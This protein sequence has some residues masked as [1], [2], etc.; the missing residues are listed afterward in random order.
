MSTSIKTQQ[1]N[2]FRVGLLALVSVIVLGATILWLRGRSLGGGEQF[3]VYFHDVD[4]MREGAPVQLMGIRV[5]FVDNVSP[6]IQNGE[7]RVAVTFS[8]QHRDVKI[9]Q[10]ST[11]S[12]EQAGL[13]GEKF[14]EIT[15]PPLQQILIPWP[16]HGLPLSHQLPVVKFLFQQGWQTVGQVES[17][18]RLNAKLARVSFRFN[19]PG[20]QIPEQGV[21]YVLHHPSNM[22]T[23]WTLQARCDKTPPSSA[24]SDDRFTILEPTRI[25]KFLEVQLASAEALQ[26]TNEKINTLLS[27]ATLASLTHTVTNLESLSREATDVLINANGLMSA[28]GPDLDHLVEASNEMV[29]LVGAVSKDLD[30]VI[31]EPEFQQNVIQTAATIHDSAEALSA[32]LKDPALKQTLAQAQS[33][34][35]DLA[36]VTSLVRSTVETQ[37]LHDKM[38]STLTTLDEGV[39][40]LNRIL[41]EVEPLVQDKDGSL[42]STL[43]D[44]RTSASELK[45]FS[46]KLNGRFLLWRLIF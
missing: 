29:S 32:L 38:G 1:M 7:Y 37:K 20:F 21:H 34:T 45:K 46:Q 14:L 31:G 26:T 39:D 36:K 28:I 42:K 33:A 6:K 43:K 5:G 41:I 40:R 13:V 8:V 17:L 23:T 44:A 30:A 35:H 9:P 3:T 24:L 18:E 27:D 12:I 10:G 22:N 25:R 15:P 11:L 19:R 16:E 2:A 4:S